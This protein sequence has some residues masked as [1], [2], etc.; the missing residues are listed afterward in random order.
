LEKI[1]GSGG[2]N[3]EIPVLAATISNKFSKADPQNLFT[4]VDLRP[5]TEARQA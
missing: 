2:E 4:R 1:P 3:S 5:T